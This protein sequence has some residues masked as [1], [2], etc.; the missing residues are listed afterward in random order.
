MTELTPGYLAWAS[1]QIHQ[2]AERHWREYGTTPIKVILF[3]ADG[4]P[5]LVKFDQGIGQDAAAAAVREHATRAGA[6]AIAMT[7]ITNTFDAEIP[8]PPHSVPPGPLPGVPDGMRIVGEVT[9][10]VT[11]L[12]VWPQ[13]DLAKAWTSDIRAGAIAALAAIVE[14]DAA[15]PSQAAGLTSWLAGLLPDSSGPST[16]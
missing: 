16:S 13:R 9:R 6:V 3:A 12:T 5:V 10:S 15:D 7:A 11:T 14:S 1:L 8:A 2:T 4:T